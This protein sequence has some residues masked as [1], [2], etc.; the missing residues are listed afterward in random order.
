L[1]VTRVVLPVDPST[2]PEP[3]LIDP[4]S[5]YQLVHQDLGD[6]ESVGE[7]KEERLMQAAPS[8]VA[9]SRQVPPKF[10]AE[11]APRVDEPE[12]VIE[13][14]Y[15]D[16]ERVVAAP[17][18]VV[19]SRQVPPKFLAEEAPRVDEPDNGREPDYGVVERVLEQAM[20]FAREMDAG[21]W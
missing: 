1:S 16:V 13:P 5:I 8:P 15:D 19:R 3:S 21:R 4:E 18:P 12:N 6:E 7:F 2:E 17:L 20:S 11:E 9:R 10:L 14:D